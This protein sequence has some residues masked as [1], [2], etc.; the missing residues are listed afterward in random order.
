MDAVPRARTRAVLCLLFLAAAC[1]PAGGFTLSPAGGVLGCLRGHGRIATGEGR[2]APA[3]A[4]N[5]AA[6]L[7]A[8]RGGRDQ[9][10]TSRGGGGGERGQRGRGRGGSGAGGAPTTRSGGSGTVLRRGSDAGEV[11]ARA[12]GAKIKFCSRTR[13]RAVCPRA[14]PA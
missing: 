11:M 3:P 7:C 4:R 5:G 2:T 9:P 12:T 14:R 10:W 6:A 8:Q 13:A 1:P